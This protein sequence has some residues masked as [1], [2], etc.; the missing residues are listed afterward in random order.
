MSEK[1]EKSE[2][3]NSEKCGISVLTINQSK[4]GD[5]IETQRNPKFDELEGQRRP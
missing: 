5:G 1:C 2:L 3:K 4:A